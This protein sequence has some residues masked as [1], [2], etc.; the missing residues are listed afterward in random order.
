[1]LNEVSKS[2]SNTLPVIPAKVIAITF[3]T[4][5]LGGSIMDGVYTGLYHQG[6]VGMPQ[7]MPPDTGVTLPCK[8]AWQTHE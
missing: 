3:S 1:M 4:G 7:V 2:A 6:D 8:P 5:A